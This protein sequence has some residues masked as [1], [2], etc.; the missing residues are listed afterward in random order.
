MENA[1]RFTMDF[2][3][4]NFSDFKKEYN[5]KEKNKKVEWYFNNKPSI[6]EGATAYI[7]CTNLPDSS[8]SKYI[9]KAT[10]AKII[11]NKKNEYKYTAELNDV[12]VFDD[13]EEKYVTFKTIKEINDKIKNHKDGED[14][15]TGWVQGAPGKITN[16]TLLDKLEAC[17]WSDNVNDFL[18]TYVNG[19]CFFRNFPIKDI[20]DDNNYKHT[21]FNKE[22]NTTYIEF[23]HLIW[24]SKG[25][26]ENDE[27]KDLLN[28]NEN[29]YC[30]CPSC[31]RMIHYGL[32]KNRQRMIDL[33]ISQMSKERKDYFVKVINK[34][35][36]KTNQSKNE[37]SIIREYLQKL[38]KTS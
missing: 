29:Y 12:K 28:K 33:I 35:N 21:T 1:Y 15:S 17:N 2:E 23:H 7:Y 25:N 34:L 18:D 26:K 30:L 14:G 4:F 8:E 37:E 32:K 36:H 27:I 22:N 38:Y 5:K 9:M 11:E 31:H 20:T 19:S 10:I 16:K 24:K 6:E 13:N 3:F